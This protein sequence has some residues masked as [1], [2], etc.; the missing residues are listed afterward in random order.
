[1]GS[2]SAG[3]IL[4]RWPAG[5][6]HDMRVCPDEDTVLRRQIH[7]PARCQLLLASDA[8]KPHPAKLERPGERGCVVAVNAT[9]RAL[10]VDVSLPP[11]AQGETRRHFRPGEGGA[12]PYCVEPRSVHRL[13]YGLT[14]EWARAWHVA[15][16]LVL[17]PE[18]PAKCRKRSS[19][20]A[21]SPSGRE[22]ARG[23]SATHRR[24]LPRPPPGPSARAGGRGTG[25]MA[26]DPAPGKASRLRACSSEDDDPSASYTFLNGSS[27]VGLASA[28]SEIA[29]R[30]TQVRRVC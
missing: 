3:A 10:A 25:P 16:T 5:A 18:T 22:A 27:P 14:G 21:R 6:W 2:L 30:L 15:H 29:D 8:G 19:A 26:I 12:F 28:L 7:V 24:A 17:T 1:M 11:P 4:A 9:G 23:P 20:S 13:T